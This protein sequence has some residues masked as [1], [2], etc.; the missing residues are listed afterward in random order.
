MAKIRIEWVPVQLFRLGLLGFDHLQLVLQQDESESDAQQDR[1]YVMEGVRDF[2]NG[3]MRLGI[4]GADGRTTLAAANVAAREDLLA[5]IGTPDHRGSRT[6]PY[7]GDAFQAW[8]TMASFA[9]DIEQQKYPYIAYGLPGSPTPTINSSSAVASLIH[10]S[11]LDPS[12]FMPFGMHFSP[13]T[14]TLL[15]TSGN[16][17]MH[18]AHGFT[19]LL[20]GEGSD[21]LAGGA[22][23]GLTEKFY[24]G[25][26]NDLF[27]FSSGFNII[28]GGQP[29]LDYAL[30]GTDV[31]DY[32]GSGT[33][34][35]TF[36][37]HWIAHKV[38]QYV[39][40][41]KGGTDHLFSVERI[42]WNGA[43]DRIELRGAELE[44][45]DVV[46]QP[47]VGPGAQHT[48]GDASQLRSG[49]LIH[50][51]SES[52]PI[53]SAIN[54]ELPPGALDLEL[55]DSTRCGRGNDLANRLIGNDADNILQ[56]L[57]GDDTLYGGGG[58]DTLDGGAGSDGYVY[59]HGDGHDVIVDNGPAEDVD[60]LL[61]AGGIA[62]EEVTLYR[63][64]A[65]PADIVLVLA[66]G[67]SIRVTDFLEGAGIERV[68]FDRA[69]A[70]TRG[71]GAAGGRCAVARR[72]GGRG[73]SRRRGHY[74]SRRE[75][76][77]RIR[78][79]RRDRSNVRAARRC[80]R[81]VQRDARERRRDPPAGVCR[82]ALLSARRRASSEPRSGPATFGRS[83]PILRMP[84]TCVARMILQAVK[85]IAF[86]RICSRGPRPDISKL[87]RRRRVARDLS[88]CGNGPVVR[89]R[90]QCRRDLQPRGGADAHRGAHYRFRDRPARRQSRGA[91]HRGPGTA[92]TRH[93]AR[94]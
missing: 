37:R 89:A 63:P 64:A 69:P 22:E 71:S 3:E 19:T 23:P 12:R 84:P 91:A 81:P 72:A 76:P 10:Y 17:R 27:H 60:E 78:G 14:D 39:A 65:A 34:T 2:H 13:G 38:P 20:G 74:S 70:W 24:G 54:H 73:T 75:R 15:G 92:L 68:V 33:V 67:G 45:D 31:I 49:T 43:S 79:R 88:G 58:N 30:D 53:R 48:S 47:V 36:N 44:E 16:D 77:W 1:W 40:V 86:A 28:H 59:L 5:K 32:S 87:M 55:T 46:R 9:R 11:G 85:R 57:A 51:G 42:Q 93:A 94:R 56:G 29:R 66:H 25:R 62:P 21:E 90:R 80:A 26:G 35:I 7:D 18:V 83:A 4:E 41:S 82:L 50:E 6:L 52:T 61:L 8:E